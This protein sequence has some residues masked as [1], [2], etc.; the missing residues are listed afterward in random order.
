ME[1]YLEL[2]NNI[3]EAVNGTADRDFIQSLR[4]LKNNFGFELSTK[5]LRALVDGTK[6][7][8]SQRVN[9][10]LKTSGIKTRREI[11]YLTIDTCSKY[12]TDVVYYAYNKDNK[13]YIQEIKEIEVLNEGKQNKIEILKVLVI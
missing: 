13:A 10:I 8:Q 4:D 12:K 6:K 1:T 5:F 11:R 2:E 9:Y 3:K 7:E